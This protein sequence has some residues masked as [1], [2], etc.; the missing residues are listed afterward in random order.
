[1]C[2]WT[3]TGGGRRAC[4]STRSELGWGWGGGGG[5]EVTRGPPSSLPTRSSH[6]AEELAHL[7]GRAPS[8][9]GL[10]GGTSDGFSTELGLHHPTSRPGQMRVS[11][12]PPAEDQN[13][14][15][16]A[17]P[18]GP[19]RGLRDVE[20]TASASTSPVKGATSKAV[21]KSISGRRR[22]PDRAVLLPRER[23]MS[24]L[25]IVG[26][27]P[28]HDHGSDDARSR[29]ASGYSGARSPSRRAPHAPARLE[30]GPSS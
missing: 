11:G 27:R 7:T 18:G 28:T 3:P 24:P 16:R 25:D 21:W 23:A 1:M 15:A 2:T 9:P 29:A 8:L 19:M 4:P 22:M 26:G 13:A 12:G 20:P 17:T 10:G 5:G 14:R 6:L 30:T